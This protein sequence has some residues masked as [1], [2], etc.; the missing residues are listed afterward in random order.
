MSGFDGFDGFY[1][2][3]KPKRNQSFI[4]PAS[5][6]GGF[7]GDLIVAI[8]GLILVFALISWII[9]LVCYYEK[10]SFHDKAKEQNEESQNSHV[11]IPVNGS[12]LESI[13][14]EY[15]ALSKIS[16]ESIQ[17]E[18]I[19]NSNLFRIM[20]QGNQVIGEVHLD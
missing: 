1:D 7:Q 3:T 11:Y 19:E 18:V 20:D 2:I 13:Q 4:V 14:E 17:V 9:G 15:I 5:E 8:I 16:N 6:F 10:C 12:K